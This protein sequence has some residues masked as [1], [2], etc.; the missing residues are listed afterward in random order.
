MRNVTVFSQMPNEPL[1]ANIDGDLLKQALLNVIQ[2]GAQAMPAGGRL[3]V[4]LH[5]DRFAV[6]VL[7]EAIISIRDEGP[8]IPDD[9]REKIFD[10]YFTTKA[11]GSGI[12]LAMTYR[13]LQLHH[14]S[15]EVQSVAG[16][17]SDFRLR[18]PL[19]SVDW[20]RRHARAVSSV[21]DEESR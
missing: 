11:G 9:I 21:S 2:N 18:I 20:G 17:G 16:Q 12:G 1:I 4:T 7:K 3:E 13:I 6:Q 19:A 15:V 8:G 14:G 5:V 10:L